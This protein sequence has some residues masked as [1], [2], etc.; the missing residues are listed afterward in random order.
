MQKLCKK[1]EECGETDFA[2]SVQHHITNNQRIPESMKSIYFSAIK[3]RDAEKKKR[4]AEEKKK[5]EAE[6]KKKRDA[7]AGEW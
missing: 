6:E 1:L 5:R 4:D 7:T 3:K 2:N